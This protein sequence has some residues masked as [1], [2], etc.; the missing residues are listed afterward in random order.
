M[1]PRLLTL[2]VTVAWALALPFVGPGHA[3]LHVHA[4]ETPCAACA[5]LPDGPTFQALCDAPEGQ[6]PDPTHHH[7]H[8]ADHDDDT[9]IVC[10]LA[11]VLPEP[12]AAPAIAVAETGPRV[13]VPCAPP[14]PDTASAYDARA[15][16]APLA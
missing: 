4:P 10:G 14:A 6:C 16:P 1:R 11:V 7:H 15:P 13:A 8:H 5:H 12:A 2:V 3:V 9:C